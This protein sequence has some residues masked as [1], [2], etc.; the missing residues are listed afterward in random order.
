MNVFGLE[1]LI[2]AFLF[3]IIGVAGSVLL[4]WLKSTVPFNIRQTV[5]SAI[6]AFV[7]SFQL[8]ATTIQ[9]LPEG[10]DDLA[11]GMIIVAMIGTVAG[12]DSLTKSSVKAAM[13]TKTVK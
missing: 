10:L 3:T 13:K 4:G 2:A 1:P 7:I 12:I 8:V 6:I 9:A 11:I 5:A